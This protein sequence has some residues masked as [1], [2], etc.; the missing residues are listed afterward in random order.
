MLKKKHNAWLL[1]VF[2]FWLVQPLAASGPIRVS[3]AFESGSLGAW[4]IE[5]NTRLVF[6]PHTDYD[7]DRVN[8][9]VTWFYGRLDNVGNREVTIEVTGLDYTVYNGKRSDILPFQRGTAPVFSYDQEHWQ[10]FTDCAFDTAKQTF[11]MRQIFGEDTVWVAYTIPY[12]FS[13]LE[14]LLD[15]MRKKSEVKVETPGH[16]VEGR[17]LYLVTVGRPQTDQ[18]EHPVVWIVARQH[19]F[20]AGG[21][22]SMEGLLRFLTSDD[23]EAENIRNKITFKLCPM[24]NPDGVAHGG[25]RFNARGVDLNRHWNTVDPLSSDPKLAPEIISIKQAIKSWRGFHR[26][27]LWINIHN[28]DMVWNEDGDYISFAAPGGEAEARRLEGI[29][30]EETGFTGPFRPSADDRSTDA[31]VAAETGAL[32]LILEMK[33]GFLEGLDRW[34]GKDIWLAHGRGLARAALR[35]LESR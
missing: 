2:L 34:T 28:N 22:W 15:E 27:D 3:D 31:V 1:V 20:E 35:F 33:T 9:A 6:V 32:S 23:P 24:L 11:R 14:S 19:A 17:P 8:T 21:S 12:T 13:R 30:R 16:S 25:T 4:R 26:L 5:G 18:G 10:R 29:L 7:Q